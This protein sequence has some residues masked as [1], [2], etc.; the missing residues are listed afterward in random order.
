MSSSKRAEGQQIIL[1]LDL[2][3]FCTEVHI[4]FNLI[5]YS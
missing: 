5:V 2:N 4:T 1:Q 3:Y